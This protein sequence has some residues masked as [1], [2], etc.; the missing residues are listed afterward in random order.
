MSVEDTSRTSRTARALA[1]SVK[2]WLTEGRRWIGWRDLAHVLSPLSPLLTTADFIVR[3][4]RARLQDDLD[5]RDPALIAW[6]TE[7]A[8]ALGRLFRLDVHGVENLPPTGPVLLVGNHN[9]GLLPLDGL[10]TLA[11]VCEHLG[12]SRALHPLAHDLILYDR[13]AHR[14]ATRA[15]IL[16]AGHESAVQAL[17]AGHM[18]L[19]YPGSDVE[20][21]R[22][23]RERSRIELAG[24]TGFLTLALRERVP[25]IPVVSAG[26]HEQW[27]VLSR[28][29]RLAKALHTGELLRTKVL[30]LA[31]AL[32]FGLTFGLLPYLPLP[33]Q[34]SLA[35]GAPITW[36]DID[37]DQAEDPV[38]LAHTYNEVAAR[39]QAILDALY[40]DR[41]PFIGQPQARRVAVE[42][43]VVAPRR[44]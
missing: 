44:T 33:A 5:A 20:T 11:A 39:M 8:M 1:G 17:R 19:V 29:D 38:V 35:F 16:R 31:L 14:F 12:P 21:F 27:I 23:W 24:R 36:P 6:L 40:V 34:T 42:R 2:R 15:G 30:P 7:A 41:V 43:L 10:F 25:I 37:P 9:G 32:P 4:D 22:T 13:V 28:G 3:H 18:V 26:T